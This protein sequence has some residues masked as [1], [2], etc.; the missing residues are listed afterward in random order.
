[1]AVERHKPRYLESICASQLKG[2][3]VQFSGNKDLGHLLDTLMH[4]VP[5]SEQF[6]PTLTL[7]ELVNIQ[8]DLRRLSKGSFPRQRNGTK[9]K[10]KNDSE[11][12]NSCCQPFYLIKL[13]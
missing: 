7:Q 12:R 1:M 13:L 8:M 6:I 3:P 10:T 5:V 2:S 11:I 4:C 9:Q